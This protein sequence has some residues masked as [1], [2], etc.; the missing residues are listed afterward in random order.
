M[1]TCVFIFTAIF[2]AV[3]TFIPVSGNTSWVV[4]GWDFP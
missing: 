1:I 3:I 4:G 2:L